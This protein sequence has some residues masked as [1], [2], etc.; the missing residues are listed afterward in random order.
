MKRLPLAIVA[1]VLFGVSV[2]ATAATHRLD[3]SASQVFPPNAAWDWAPGSLRT[4]MS[5]VYLNV[6]VVVRIDTRAW[7]GRQGQVYMALPLDADGQVTAEWRTQGKLLGGRLVSGERALVF[8]G[9]VP[10]PFLEDTIHVRLSTDARTLVGD[11]QRLAFHFELD[12]P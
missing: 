8:S 7:A 12:T 1:G 11:I 2:G 5:T 9:T 10:G 6:R 4:G 3:D